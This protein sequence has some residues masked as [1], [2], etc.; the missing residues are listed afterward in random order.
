GLRGEWGGA[1]SLTFE[2]AP[3]GTRGLFSAWPQTGVPLGLLLS[4]L[5]VNLACLPG[6]YALQGWTCRIPFLA[7]IVLVVIGL[8]IRLNVQEPPSFRNMVATDNRAK[9]PML[10]VLRDYPKQ[11]ILGVGARFSESITF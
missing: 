11:I 8:L 9:T 6:D 5:A 10:E 2:H 3:H 4:T 1:A 7:S